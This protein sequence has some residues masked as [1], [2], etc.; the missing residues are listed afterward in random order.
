M[1]FTKNGNSLDTSFALTTDP[2]NV[3]ID[4][5][6]YLL[7]LDLEADSQAVHY[8][9]AIDIPSDE[10][11]TLS[12]GQS[13]A[14]EVIIDSLSFAAVSGYVD[15][16]TVDIDTVE[17]EIDLPAELDNLEFAQ[18]EMNFAFQSNIALPVFLDLQLASFNDETG[19]SV[20]K[21][22]EQVN[23][24]EQ[25]L[26]SIDSAQ[27]LINIQPNRIVASGTAEVGS[28]EE[29]G[30]VTTADTISGSL[31][32]AAP[33][34]F[35]INENSRI[36]VDAK[37][38]ESIAADAVE[39]ARVF[40]D[41]QNK[42]EFGAD[43]AVLVTTDTT[44]FENG[45]ADTLTKVGIQ[46]D[47]A[48]LDSVNLDESKFSLLAREGNYVKAVIGLLG[49]EEGPS[50]FLATDTMDVELYISVE[51]ILDLNDGGDD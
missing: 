3:T 13:I 42:F 16:V 37:E 41:Y 18:I 47:A 20:V 26:F 48:G 45:T 31:I 33:L 44:G 43:I 27:H 39:S 46:A 24:I 15:P 1:E 25:P 10:E 51:A 12:F 38:L 22:I 23:I 36:E 6:G 8:V 49:R 5:S 40:L 30:S 29:Y 28:L 34:A 7:D 19:E 32:M 14:I 2:L 21:R 9:S 35:E 4:L 17:Q 50:R 11:M